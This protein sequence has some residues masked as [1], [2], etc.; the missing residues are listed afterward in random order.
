MGAVSPVDINAV[1]LWGTIFAGLA[2]AGWLV[3]FVIGEVRAW[4]AKRAASERNFVDWTHEWIEPDVVRVICLGPDK[5]AS[6]HLRV[7]HDGRVYDHDL[8]AM[9]A[10]RSVDVTVPAL[11][12]EWE[13][14]MEARN[15]SPRSNDPFGILSVAA[16]NP[17]MGH[18]VTAFASFDVHWISPRG[19]RGTLSWRDTFMTPPDDKP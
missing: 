17:T 4:K 11:R 9:E 6:G 15:P 3:T 12:E 10:G 18:G 8:G 13:A 5:I 14:I 19:N 16:I 7:A 2:F 1:T